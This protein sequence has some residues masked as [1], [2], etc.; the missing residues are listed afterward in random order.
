[1]GSKSSS[2]LRVFWNRSL[3][4]RLCLQNKRQYPKPLKVWLQGQILG[5][6]NNTHPKPKKGK[7]K[8]FMQ[9]SKFKHQRHFSGSNG[10]SG[11]KVGKWSVVGSPNTKTDGQ[12]VP[13]PLTTPDSLNE[14]RAND[15]ED[16]MN[17]GKEDT[18]IK[19]KKRTKKIK[20]II[21]PSKEGVA[22]LHK[23]QWVTINV[24]KVL[25]QQLK[26]K[27]ESVNDGI[28]DMIG[29][30]NE[31]EVIIDGRKVNALLDTGVTN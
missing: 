30:A 8:K 10:K 20:F 9:G 6:G 24:A 29:P 26:W 17:N 23:M 1:M 13:S 18:E 5:L 11:N 31:T 12:A 4:K 2:L 22:I 25:S 3:L 7:Q 14:P 19:D 28:I 21:K 15:T 16:S 27:I